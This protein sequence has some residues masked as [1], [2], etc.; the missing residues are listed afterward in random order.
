MLLL[1]YKKFGQSIQDVQ[2]FLNTV[3]LKN[4]MAIYMPYL[5]DDGEVRLFNKLFVRKLFLKQ[6]NNP[7]LISIKPTNYGS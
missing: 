4:I 7:F 2:A 3:P 1:L 6:I 5:S